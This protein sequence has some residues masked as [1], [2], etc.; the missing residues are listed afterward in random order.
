MNH[1]RLKE[2]IRNPAFTEQEFNAFGSVDAYI[3]AA[4]DGLEGVAH[5]LS[6][7]MQVLKEKNNMLSQE[8]E[9]SRTKLNAAT[10]E[11]EGVKKFMR[12]AH[13]AESIGQL[14]KSLEAAKEAQ[15]YAE[16][17]GEISGEE[18]KSQPRRLDPDRA[19][20]SPE[21]LPETED[22]AAGGGGGGAAGE[23]EDGARP[24]R[25]GET[26]DAAAPATCG[27]ADGGGG[28][29]R[30]RGRGRR[31][32]RAGCGRGARPAAREETG[33]EG[34]TRA[35]RAGGAVEAGVPRGSPR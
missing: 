19:R 4:Q 7:D 29:A 34:P 18:K 31:L 20:G 1:R 30:R 35:L 2:A 25:L 14:E 3:L 24:E 8:L 9:A 22:G 23:E 28:R 17:L 11:L 15:D 10:A 32:A 33:Q 16:R 13:A 6:K 21:L 5:L 26:A 27:G 12:E